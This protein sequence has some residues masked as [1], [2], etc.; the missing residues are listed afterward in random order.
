MSKDF[1]KTEKYRKKMSLATKGEKNGFFGKKHTEKCKEKFR[2]IRKTWIANSKGGRIMSHGYILI[3]KPSHPHSDMQGYIL[4]H[5]LIAELFLDRYLKL[6]EI[7]HHRDG[8]G[9]NNKQNNL[10]VFENHCE[11]SRYEN[12]FRNRNKELGG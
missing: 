9:F 1:Y 6:E 8:N 7:V 10:F 12:W 5:R 3:K 11:H 4:E 2:K